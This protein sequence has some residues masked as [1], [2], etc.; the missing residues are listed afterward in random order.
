MSLIIFQIARQESLVAHQ[1]VIDKRYTRNPVTMFYLSLTL[2]II[3]TSGKVPHKVSPVHEVH[4]IDEEELDVFPLGRHL[5]HNHFATLIER[6]GL[7]FYAAQ[8]VFVSFGMRIAIH[9]WEQHILS[10]LIF[11]LVTYLFVAVF[12]CRILFFLTLINRRSFSHVVHTAS[13]D[14]FQSHF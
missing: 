2:K 4:L 7:T 14:F 6:Y 5:H 11:G 9:T 13:V 1:E 12:F 10:I 3:L 8:P